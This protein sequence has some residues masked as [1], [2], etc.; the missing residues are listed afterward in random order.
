MGRASRRNHHRDERGNRASL[1]TLETALPATSRPTPPPRSPLSEALVQLIDPY[2]QE[3]TTLTAYKVLIGIGTLA[4]NL[5]LFSEAE[6][7]KQLVEA[8]RGRDLPDPAVLREMIQ[9]L[10][11]RKEHLFPHDRRTI[12]DYEVTTTP[13]GYHVTVVSAGTA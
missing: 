10:S 12:V 6:R 3:A 4:W 13:N 8:M 9:T 5:T 2:R 11:Q 1:D 7:E